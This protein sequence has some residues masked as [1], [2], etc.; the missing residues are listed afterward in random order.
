M[1][2]FF[3]CVDASHLQFDRSEAQNT[4]IRQFFEETAENHL[5]KLGHGDSHSDVCRGKLHRSWNG[6]ACKDGVVCGIECDSWEFGRLHVE[7]LPPTVR[8]ISMTK[9]NQC[10]EIQTSRLPRDLRKIDACENLIYGT[11]DLRRLPANTREVILDWNNIVGPIFLTDLPKRFEYLGMC[12]NSIR[13][14]VVPLA[15][16]PETIRYIELDGN[17]IRK[18]HQVDGDVRTDVAVYGA[19][20]YTDGFIE[21][22]KY[23]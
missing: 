10:Y 16:L 22:A 9:S 1:F 21:E 14:K 15:N 11:F 6:I 13:Q 4:L 2:S 19:N 8:R 12:N 17:A 7:Y 18:L 20:L 3:L 5:H 23:D